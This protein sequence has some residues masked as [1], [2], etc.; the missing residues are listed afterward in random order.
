MTEFSRTKLSDHLVLHVS[1]QVVRA[2]LQPGDNLASEHE[3]AAAFGISKPVVRESLRALASLG[4]DPRPAGQAHDCPR[5]A[6]AQ[7]VHDRRS[8]MR[9]AALRS[10]P[11]PG[12]TRARCRAPSWPWM[13]TS[14]Q[15]RASWCELE[16][17][18]IQVRPAPL[19]QRLGAVVEQEQP[20]VEQRRPTPGRRRRAS[21]TRPGAS[22]A[23]GPPAW[24]SRRSADMPCP[25]A[26]RR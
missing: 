6:F 2:E 5:R 21:P 17:G 18:E 24:P 23:A 25:R 9:R 8:R 20:E 1:R 10:G 11:S 15:S 7:F 26:I 12:S 22:R 14:F 13:K 16:L 19:P 4:L 3:L